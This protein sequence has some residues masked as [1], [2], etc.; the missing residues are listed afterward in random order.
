[1]NQYI[2]DKLEELE[3]LK[4]DISALPTGVEIKD[5]NIGKNNERYYAVIT[6]V[7]GKGAEKEYRSE[8]N[9]YNVKDIFQNM[10]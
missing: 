6:Y 4:I 5:V 10:E 1:M 2:R 3:R 7:D 8:Q 9:Q